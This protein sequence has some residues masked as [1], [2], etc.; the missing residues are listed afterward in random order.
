MLDAFL[1]ALEDTP[2]ARAVREG[3]TLYP[4][5]ELAHLAGLAV[6]IGSVTAFDL[7]LLG[8]SRAL[9]VRALGAHLLRWTWTGFAL[10]AVSGLLLSAANA[11]ALAADTAPQVKPTVIALAG[12]N[13]AVFHD[14]HA[15]TLASWDT[16]TA[17]PPF[18]R[19]TGAVSLRLW[20]IA[21]TCGR[22][23]AYIG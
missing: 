23:I 9:S 4:A 10:V 3:P 16:G 19:L 5:V 12:C 15:R 11:T 14:A 6:L 18:V 17:P 2:V 20:L 21:L 13:A 7:R 22:L 8:V 1:R